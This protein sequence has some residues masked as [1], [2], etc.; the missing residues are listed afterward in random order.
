VFG[1]VHTETTK[2]TAGDLGIEHINP[3]CGIIA[4]EFNKIFITSTTWKLHLGLT[5]TPQK[6]ILNAMSRIVSQM[7]GIAT[8][9]L[10]DRIA[11]LSSSITA[12]QQS[13]VTLDEH[14][15][16]HTAAADIVPA[17]YPLLLGS[18][19]HEQ[20]LAAYLCSYYKTMCFGNKHNAVITAADISDLAEDVNLVEQ[21]L[22]DVTAVS[23]GTAH[24]TDIINWAITQLPIWKTSGRTCDMSVTEYDQH[25]RQIIAAHRP[26]LGQTI[27]LPCL[28][29]RNAFV[30][31]NILTLPWVINKQLWLIDLDHHDMVVFNSNQ[32]TTDLIK[33]SELTALYPDLK[34]MPYYD[35]FG[36]AKQIAPSYISY[37]IPDSTTSEPAD[38]P[39]AINENT[40]YVNH[41][42]LIAIKK[43]RWI[44]ANFL[45][46]PI[47]LR[48]KKGAQTFSSKIPTGTSILTLAVS[49]LLKPDSTLFIVKQSWRKTALNFFYDNDSNQSLSVYD[50]TNF[51]SKNLSNAWYVLFDNHSES[52]ITIIIAISVCF[53]ILCFC[54]S[55]FSNPTLRK[56]VRSVG[57]RYHLPRDGQDVCGIR[58]PPPST[59]LVPY[60]PRVNSSQW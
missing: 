33:L 19:E 8:S 57:H 14:F 48:Y 32:Q 9:A 10:D 31:F 50:K 15:A 17:E 53:P 13:L 4:V 30:P 35:G 41:A 7:D 43:D 22:N 1:R 54:Y 34:R 45:N 11:A 25:F 51:A 49:V 20:H 39:L 23:A 44:V 12:A 6:T 2:T 38:C 3:R 46:T 60:L 52:I 21:I 24:D 18:L 56:C 36:M 27:I 55:Y 58:Q 37:I 47:G 29:E 40:D 59:A 42:Y 28:S 16:H 5:T 26:L